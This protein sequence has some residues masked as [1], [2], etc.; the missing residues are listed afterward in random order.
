MKTTIAILAFVVVPLNCEALPK[1]AIRID[2]KTYYRVAPGDYRSAK[3]A[4]AYTKSVAAALD[5][6]RAEDRER[7]VIDRYTL[8]KMTPEQR[9][10][11]KAEQ[12]PKKG[13]WRRLVEILLL[14]W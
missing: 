13:F 4:E 9:E 7:A 11:L 1:R 14:Q 6:Y 12:S 5:K 3:D 8:A 10:Q 2:G